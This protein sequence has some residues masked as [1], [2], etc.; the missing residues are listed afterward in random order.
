[1]SHTYQK[2]RDEDEEH[3]IELYQNSDKP[4]DPQATNNEDSYKVRLRIFVRAISQCCD[5]WNFSNKQHDTE[6][7]K[8]QMNESSTRIVR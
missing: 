4:L 7:T 3:T 8:L 2:Q 1:M 6:F 5:C